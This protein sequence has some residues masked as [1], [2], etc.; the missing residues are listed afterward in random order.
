MFICAVGRGVHFQR[1]LCLLGLMHRSKIFMVKTR[2][3]TVSI[4]VAVMLSE[5]TEERSHTEHFHPLTLASISP[6]SS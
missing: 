4:H 5:I 2:G 3:T 1:R 6:I